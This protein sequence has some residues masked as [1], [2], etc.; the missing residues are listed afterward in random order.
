[1]KILAPAQIRALDAYT[2]QH[3]P[4]A[5]VDLMERAALAFTS[6]FAER[7]ETSRPVKVFCGLGNNGGDGLAIARLLVGKRYQVSVHVVDYSDKKSEDFM[8]NYE[9]L[10]KLVIIQHIKNVDHFPLVDDHEIFIDAILGSGLSRP[11]EGLVQEVIERINEQSVSSQYRVKQSATV[12]SVDIASG[13]YADEATPTGSTIIQPHFTVAFQVPKLAF[14]LPQNA[15]FVREWSCV[16]IGLNKAFIAKT[17]TP[18]YYL[19][20]ALAESLIKPRSKYAHK[21]TFGH[22]LLVAGSYGKIGA[23]VLAAKACLRSGVGLL[24]VRIPQCGYEIIQTAVP[25]AMALVDDSYECF[26][27]VP[28]LQPYTAVGIGPGLGKSEDTLKALSDVLLALEQPL[29]SDDQH[30]SLV[31]DADALNL[32]AENREL[33][34][35]LPPNAILTP[36]PKEF[37]RLAGKAEN[38]FDRLE[39]LKD[40]A[41]TH[42]VYVVLKG[43]NTAIATPEG[44]VYFNSTGNPGMATGGTGDVLTGIIT[45]LLAQSYSPLEAA[46]IGV[47]QHGLSGDRAAAQRGQSALIA[48]DLIESLGW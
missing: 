46:L 22:A 16:E 10:S 30:P 3:E 41:Q 29:S 37:E 31:L 36:H 38:D 21:G 48:S 47:Y 25:E 8:A 33:L 43:A 9:R 15:S 4:I 32:L 40:F 7:F 17:S 35:R 13:L 26:T 27:F 44:L 18:Y 12:V 14:L 20:Q 28:P 42:Q 2:I 6:W 1:M 11:T 23:A 24:T 45:A 39:L 34:K 19:D 5:S